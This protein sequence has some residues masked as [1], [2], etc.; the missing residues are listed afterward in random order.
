MAPYFSDNWGI[1]GH[2]TGE[3]EGGGGPNIFLSYM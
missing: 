3:W 2:M 1:Y